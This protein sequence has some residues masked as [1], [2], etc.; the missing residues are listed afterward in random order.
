[1]TVRI[2]PANI[3]DKILSLFGKE[4]EV[5][6]PDDAGKAFNQIGPYVQILGKRESFLKALTRKTVNQKPETEG[7]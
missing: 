1:M 7:K 3:W 5:I 2:P 4:R 6:V